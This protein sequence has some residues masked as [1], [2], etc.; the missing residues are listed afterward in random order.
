MKAVEWIGRNVCFF[1]RIHIYYR[2]QKYIQHSHR[3]HW[4]CKLD[5]LSQAAFKIP[6]VYWPYATRFLWGEYIFEISKDPL[7]VWLTECSQ[8]D[9]VFL[10]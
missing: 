9:T 4:N 3:T 2:T 6:L 5:L 10:S 8:S 1:L 7:K